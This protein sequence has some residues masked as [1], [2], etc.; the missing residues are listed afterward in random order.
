M[1]N[2]MV[3]LT[4]PHRLALLLQSTDQNNVQQTQMPNM[5]S[6]SNGL[7]GQAQGMGMNMLMNKFGQPGMQ[8]GTMPNLSGRALQMANDRQY[9]DMNWGK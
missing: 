6:P 5:Q 1:P 3:Q 7:L 9:E 4:N 8:D 2:Q